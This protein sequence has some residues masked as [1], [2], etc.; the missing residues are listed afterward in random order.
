MA[1]VGE[2][3]AGKSTLMKILSG[4]FIIRVVDAGLVYLDAPSHAQEIV[5]GVIILLAV[6]LD[7]SRRGEI[8]WLRLPGMR[9]G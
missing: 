3:E 5:L 1:L 6:A 8:K 9:S 2:N 4:V 7:V